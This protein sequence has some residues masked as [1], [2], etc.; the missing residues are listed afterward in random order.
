[1]RAIPRAFIY[2]LLYSEHFECPAATSR[3]EPACTL[4]LFPS[5]SLFLC[6]SHS[7]LHSLPRNKC[8]TFARDT[9]CAARISYHG[10]SRWRARA[11]ALCVCRAATALRVRHTNKSRYD[12]LRYAANNSRL[13]RSVGDRLPGTEYFD[14]KSNSAFH[15]IWNASNYVMNVARRGG[16]GAEPK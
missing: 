8:I 11:R 2:V 10:E 15:K 3:G 1:M 6:F 13:R 14:Q 12:S 4:G 9:R 16:E 5:L 7:F